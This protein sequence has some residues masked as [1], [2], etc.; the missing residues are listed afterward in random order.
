[1]NKEALIENYF[2]NRLSE[3]E[4]QELEQL[5]E[6]D[7]AFRQE[8]YSQLEIKQAIAHEKHLPLKERLQKLD[9]PQV[10]KIAWYMYA[11]AVSILIA[12]GFLFYDTQPDYQQ[13]YATHF[14]PYPNVVSLTT[15]SD[16][17]G[18][19][20]TAV[21]FELYQARMYKEAATVFQGVY[22][23]HPEEYVHFYYGMSL[24]ANDNTQ[25][26]INVLEKYPWHEENSDFTTAVN[27]YVGLGYLKLEQPNQA[28]LYLQKVAD[29]ENMLSSR[30]KE[31]LDQLD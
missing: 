9:Q 22:K 16:T 26:G 17:N 19:D 4:F 29:G 24:L 28:R 13:L 1:M 3:E 5:L 31:V 6:K 2:S 12:I 7:D 15:R 20:I 30:A 21:A 14:E 10:K 23:E 27:W 8:F 11:A 18:E 25:E